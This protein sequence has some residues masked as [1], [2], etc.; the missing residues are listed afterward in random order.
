MN[1]HV[2]VSRIVFGVVVG[3]FGLA[4][5][6]EPIK[7]QSAKDLVGAWTAVSVSVD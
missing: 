4:L 6:A 2:R 5:A 7:A 1:I 3:V